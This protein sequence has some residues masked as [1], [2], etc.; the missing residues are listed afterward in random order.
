[1]HAAAAGWS[2]GGLADAV[3]ATGTKFALGLTGAI[4]C[5]TVI[6]VV[7]GGST[8]L[9]RA[10]GVIF[11]VG[12]ATPPPVL[13]PAAT[14]AFGS[15]PAIATSVVVVAGLW[16]VLLNVMSSR[17]QLS[18]TRREVAATLRMSRSATFW[19]VT[20]PS[21]VP[22]LMTGIRVAAPLCLVLS[23]LVEM[24]TS[25]PGLGYELLA[26]QQSFNSAGAFAVLVIT[27]SIGLLVS[28]SVVVVQTAVDRRWPA[29]SAR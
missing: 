13:A 7:V 4:V 14:L 27:A 16:P 20:L 2:D 11:E 25:L 10:T 15:T 17:E 24:L 6:G 3:V 19:K 21:V 29:T 9:R 5:G 23:L 12:R 26:A 18:G 1:M 22:G 8:R 28:L